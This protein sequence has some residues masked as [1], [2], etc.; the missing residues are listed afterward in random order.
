[1][2]RISR[3]NRLKEVFEKIDKDKQIVIE[4][5]LE[6]VVFIE[7]RLAELKRLPLLRVS[8][9]NPAKQVVTPAGKQYKEYLQQ[10]NNCVKILLSALSRYGIEEE[11]EFD[12]WLKEQGGNAP[13]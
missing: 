9:K 1:M 7:K 13:Q 2:R 8:E 12:K 10:Y 11:D 5:L 3:I 6:D 4:P